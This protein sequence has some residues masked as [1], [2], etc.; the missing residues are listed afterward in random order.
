LITNANNIPAKVKLIPRAAFDDRTG[1]SEDG[2]YG[3]QT[4]TPYAMFRRF[5]FGPSGLPCTAPP[6][7]ML[8]A[9]DLQQGT[10]RWQVPFGSFRG[11][12]R[13]N[14]PEQ[15][16]SVS[17][18]GPIVTATGLVFIAGTFDPLLRA[19]DVE[20]GKELWSAELPASGHATPITY[21]LRSNGKQYVVIA[22]GGHAKVSE[23][24]LGDSLVAFALRDATE[25][26]RHRERTPQRH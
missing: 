6:W 20:T 3:T 21:Q 19:F 16:G 22:A 4:G 25:T 9:V 15:S 12:S 18:G 7:G 26:P 17:L 2:E 23:E 24:R 11:F 8:T 5:L 1:L 10:I 13:T 14:P